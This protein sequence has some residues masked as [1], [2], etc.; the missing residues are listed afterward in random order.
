[1]E[2]VRLSEFDV[3]VCDAIGQCKPPSHLGFVPEKN[4]PA[5]KK[6]SKMDKVQFMNVTKKGRFSGASK[7][8]LD[9]YL[10]KEYSL[11]R[12]KIFR[13]KRE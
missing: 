12:P 9:L 1:M 2:A 5:L 8:S 3:T 11:I 10:K 7:N 6:Y 4:K 13:G